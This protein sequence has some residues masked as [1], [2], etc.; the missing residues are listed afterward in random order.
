[1]AEAG[2]NLEADGALMAISGSA[3]DAD[4]PVSP[5]LLVVT[6]WPTLPGLAPI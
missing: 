6:S 3:M 5:V 1:L 2:G 4:T